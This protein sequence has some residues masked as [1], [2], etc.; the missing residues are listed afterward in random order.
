MSDIDEQIW[1][2]RNADL[3]VI[4]AA[5]GLCW[6]HAALPTPSRP[7]PLGNHLDALCNAMARRDEVLGLREEQR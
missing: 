4:E 7:T 6:V 2:Q 1:A 3:D 5:R